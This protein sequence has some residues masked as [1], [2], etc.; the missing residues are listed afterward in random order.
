[1]DKIIVTSADSN[2]F[3]LLK[4][5]ILSVLDQWKP[6]TADICVLDLGLS[7]EE[8]QWLHE[9]HIRI[10]KGLDLSRKLNLPIK[11]P[12]EMAA[13]LRAYLPSILPGY[14]KYLWMDADTWVQD[15]TAIEHYFQYAENKDV[16]AAIEMDRTYSFDHTPG[17]IWHHVF[18]WFYKAGFGKEL[19]K[20]LC[21]LP[22]INCGV[23]SA[24]ADSPLWSKWPEFI[25]KTIKNQ[26]GFFLAD[27]IPFNYLIY[28]NHISSLLLPAEYNWL[29]VCSNPA[30]GAA[31]KKF[32]T[33]VPPHSLIKIMH[34]AAIN[35]RD[36]M[37]RVVGDDGEEKSVPLIYGVRE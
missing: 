17:H 7:A 34:L 20:K 37:A 14:K 22:V 13:C 29:V 36:H 18:T 1:M 16:V 5:L 35:R 3:T 31:N 30:L 33:P 2:F 11:E 4:S 21:P 23:F 32:F 15:P 27:Q 9:R 25:W 19:A 10:E 26:K 28:E 24:K 6:V 12:K 8:T